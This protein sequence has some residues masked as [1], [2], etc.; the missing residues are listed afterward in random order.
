LKGE[1][2]IYSSDGRHS[3]YIPADIIK[4][5]AF[6]FTLVDRLSIHVEGKRLIIEKAGKEG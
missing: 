4:D 3:I 2:K 5:S 1:T 6:P